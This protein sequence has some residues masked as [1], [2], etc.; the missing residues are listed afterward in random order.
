MILDEEDISQEIYL[1]K[2]EGSKQ[3]AYFIRKDLFK[4]RKWV[5]SDCSRFPHIYIDGPGYDGLLRCCQNHLN[6]EIKE[7]LGFL[8]DKERDVIILELQGFTQMEIGDILG[9][10][11][12]AVSRRRGRSIRKI[13]N[14]WCV[15]GGWL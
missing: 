14:M 5:H 7:V 9:I 8:N 13:R 11:S 2:L 3:P 6:M 10:C 12:S 1:R 15:D 4:S